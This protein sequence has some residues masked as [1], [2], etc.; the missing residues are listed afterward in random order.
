MRK[1]KQQVELQKLIAETRLLRHQFSVG[2]R[3]V[4]WL[5]AIAGM[6][7]VLTAII[8]LVGLYVSIS[9][10]QA[11]DETTRKTQQQEQLNRSIALLADDNKAKQLAGISTL[12]SFIRSDDPIIHKQILSVLA[13]ILA[14]EENKIV[15]DAI[16]S[17]FRNMELEGF[18]HNVLA[19]VLSQF[20][21][22]SAS[23][24]VEGKLKRERKGNR[25]G[26]LS[27]DSVE[28]RAMSVSDALVLF[29]RTGV[30]FTELS[31]IYC[32]RWLKAYQHE[33]SSDSRA[34]D[35]QLNYQKLDD[36]SPRVGN[37]LL[38]FVSSMPCLTKTKS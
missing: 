32:A 36:Q 23:L 29:L 30:E 8:A 16:L 35:L 9:R 37:S 4:E 28:A 24:V 14:V 21:A 10:F 15:R 3:F 2:A 38:P 26:W 13:N 7:G 18:D 31:G 11:E 34:A 27:P 6:A 5:K 19:G 20:A 12:E 25:F 17:S 22:S 1:R 33:S